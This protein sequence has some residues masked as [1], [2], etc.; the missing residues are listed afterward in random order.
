MCLRFIKKLNKT[1]K[2]TWNILGIAS[3]CCSLSCDWW[4]ERKWQAPA[5][6]P[7][8][9]NCSSIT[10]QQHQSFLVS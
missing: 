6:G 2:N 5:V 8:L 10:Q 9:L 3:P 7:V 1:N 4:K